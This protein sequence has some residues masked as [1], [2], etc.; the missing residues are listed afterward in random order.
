[1]AIGISV[2]RLRKIFAWRKEVLVLTLLVKN[3]E[4][5]ILDNILFHYS[6]GVDHVIVTDNGS[7]DRTVTILKK[8]QKDGFVHL[9]EEEI[10]NQDKLVN[11]MGAI[12]KEK[13]SATI[14]I[15]ADADEFWN[16]TNNSNLKKTFFNTGKPAVLVDRKDVLPTPDC[17]SKEFPQESLNIVTKHLISENVPKDSQ[18]T[19]L[20]LF[21]LP[22]KV[23]FSV[24]QSLQTVG[25]GNHNLADGQDADVTGEIVIFHFPFKSTQR[26]TEKVMIAG[27]AMKKVKTTPETWWHWK[28]WYKEYRAG[29]LD[30]EI[31][32]LVPNLG[33]VPGIKY[34]QFNYDSRVFQPIKKNR[35]LWKYRSNQIRT[36]QSHL[37]QGD[38]T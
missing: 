21:R 20:F 3:E 15:H 17:K 2:S 33:E 37:Q 34:E 38:P 9:I 8:L 14:L 18:T 24:K 32:I 31:D 28:R 5:I 10:Y 13:Y 1:M 4:D 27:E 19:S 23:M 35:R 29:T 7:T 26:F 12:A 25:I 11:K 36:M 6:R 30:K 16:P 22:P